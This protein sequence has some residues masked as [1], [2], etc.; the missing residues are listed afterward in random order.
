[1]LHHSMH[2]SH[3]K[4]FATF[5][6]LRVAGYTEKKKKSSFAVHAFRKNWDIYKEILIR[7]KWQ[8]LSNSGYKIVYCDVAISAFGLSQ[9]LSYFA[10]CKL[11]YCLEVRILCRVTFSINSLI[12]WWFAA[13]PE[14][15]RHEGNWYLILNCIR[16][17]LAYQL[18]CLFRISIN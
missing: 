18:I 9:F 8:C 11:S 4:R 6:M 14:M 15:S 16:L 17:K 13:A 7:R 10:F 12:A 2:H 1:M 5:I 3:A